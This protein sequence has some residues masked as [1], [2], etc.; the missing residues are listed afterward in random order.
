MSE[1]LNDLRLEQEHYK[2][3]DLDK[4]NRVKM[5]ADHIEK[6]EENLQ[7]AEKEIELLSKKLDEVKSIY[8]DNDKL[9]GIAFDLIDWVEKERKLISMTTST[10]NNLKSFRYKN[11]ELEAKLKQET[12]RRKEAEKVVDKITDSRFPESIPLTIANRLEILEMEARIYQSKYMK[13]EK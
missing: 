6:L 7:Q 11:K 5:I 10:F 13:D 8:S 1:L 3:G 9:E 2:C 4:S 12:K